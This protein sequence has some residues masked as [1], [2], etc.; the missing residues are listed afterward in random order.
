MQNNKAQLK[1]NCT[2]IR[3]IISAL[4][5]LCAGA[6]DPDRKTFHSYDLGRVVRQY[7]D[8]LPK[9]LRFIAFT[10]EIT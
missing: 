9:K 6:Y 10:V 7:S 4:K 1:T 3:S 8:L 5:G 2:R